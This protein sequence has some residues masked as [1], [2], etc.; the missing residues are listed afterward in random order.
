M[1]PALGN[2]RRLTRVLETLAAGNRRPRGIAVALDMEGRVVQAYLL[3]GAWLGLIVLEPEP[4]LTRAGLDYVHAGAQRGF[5]LAAL[6]H[7]HPGLALIDGEPPSTTLIAE[8]IR[9]AHPEVSV[10]AARRQAVSVR[11]LVEPAWRVRPKR[12]TTE[13]LGFSFASPT[14]ARPAPIDVRAGRD[15]SPD[16]YVLVLRALLDSGELSPPRMR[17]IL[18][19][20]GGGDCPLG[21]YVAM[22]V[23]RGDAVRRGEDLV[24]TAGAVARRDLADSVVSVALSD[25]DFR[26]HVSASLRGEAGDVRRFGGWM[27]RLFA[28][29]DLAQ[30]LDR[31]LFGRPLSSFPLAGAPGADVVASGV[32]F[33]GDI[34]RPGMAFALPWSLTTLTSGLGA[35]NRALRAA[36]PH[37]VRMP[38]VVD[39]RWG[40]HG[41]LLGPGEVSPRNVPDMVSLRSRLLRATPGFAILVAFG[42][43]ARRG[44]LRLRMRH[45]DVFVEARRRPTRRLGECLEEIAERRGWLFV[46]GSGSATWPLLVDVGEALGLVTRT[47]E[48]LVLDET[49]FLRFQIDPEHRQIRDDLQTLVDAVESVAC[50]TLGG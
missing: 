3:A 33:V 21:G 14:A 36:N 9:A 23:R 34:A 29:G 4:H 10:T 28:G 6:V 35:V 18:D 17:A 39:R 26:T 22:A 11:R 19:N 37:E 30:T 7:G 12:A 40:G 47:G 15:E 13:Q 44:S 1:G 24:V 45:G 49:L 5:V 27:R 50:S 48:W 43:L 32:P 8:R 16:A 2:P 31:I 42:V 25:P 46:R 38:D 41:G 20:G